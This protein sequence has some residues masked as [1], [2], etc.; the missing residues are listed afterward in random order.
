M[1][2]DRATG[3]DV[4]LAIGENMR[5]SLEPLVTKTIAPSLYQV[6]L[7]ADDYDHLRTLFGELEEE[8][9]KLLDGELARLN[10]GAMPALSRLLRKDGAP[11]APRYVSAEGR[12]S[13]RF[14][15][16]PNGTLNPG[17]VEVVSEF[18]RP[19]EAGYGAGS[20]THRISTTRRLGQMTTRRDTTEA[21]AAGVA[22]GAATM[23]SATPQ[24]FA[25]IL[26]QDDRGKHTFLMT[27]DE[28]V[29][30][31]QAPDVWADLS[32]DTSLDVSREHA[33]LQRTP[34]GTFRIKDLSKLGTTVNGAPLPRSLEAADGGVRDLD[35]WM[36]LPDRARIGLAGIVY[37]DFERTSQP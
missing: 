1:T 20:K 2:K 19:P 27:K 37:L 10:R 4:V 36:D 22:P 15:E 17:D 26:Y 30:G 35:R 7:H 12:W 28:I 34:A 29:I 25:R 11:Q 9:K 23:D 6:Y 33:R 8:A 14:Q 18:A 32:L 13:I 3:R 21:P 24:A 16:D 31:R 5:Q